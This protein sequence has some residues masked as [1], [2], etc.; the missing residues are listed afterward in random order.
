[1]A[2]RGEREGTHRIA[3]GGEVHAGHSLPASQPHLTPTLSPLKGGEGAN[4]GAT[5]LPSPRESGER[6]GTR[7]VSDGEGEVHLPAHPLFFLV[8]P[9]SPRPSPP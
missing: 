9:T 4:D 3:K 7:R 2:L 8:R 1:M 5:C 6:E